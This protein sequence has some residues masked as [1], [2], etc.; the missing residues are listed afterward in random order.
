MSFVNEVV[1]I[2]WPR[3]CPSVEM[4]ARKFLYTLKFNGPV[5]ARQDCHFVQAL[6]IPV[7]PAMVLWWQRIRCLVLAVSTARPVQSH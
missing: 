4:I 5:V 3:S 1:K 6:L 7:A 2:K